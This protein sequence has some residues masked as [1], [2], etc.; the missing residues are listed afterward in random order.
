M[1][2]PLL[3]LAL[4]DC[5]LILLPFPYLHYSCLHICAS[6]VSTA[7]STFFCCY[8]K[9]IFCC[10]SLTWWHFS[11]QQQNYRSKSVLY[12]S[13]LALFCL[14]SKS[15]R[16]YINVV[17]RSTSRRKIIGKMQLTFYRVTL[18]FQ[19]FLF[20]DCQVIE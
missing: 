10:S 7:F 19:L 6:A 13:V 12:Y 8:F 20:F 4:W 17:I 5:L 18:N 9:V 3:F 14:H 16:D 15:F 11:H 2:F 1:F